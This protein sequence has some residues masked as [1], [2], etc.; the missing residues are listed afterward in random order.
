MGALI[1][2]Q[3]FDLTDKAAVEAPAFNLAWHYALDIRSESDCYFCEK[4]LR[5][6]RAR[7]WKAG[8]TRCFSVA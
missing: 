6:Y 7:S 8:W 2:R 1:L 4:T 3:M 5:N